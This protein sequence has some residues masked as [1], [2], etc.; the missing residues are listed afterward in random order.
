MNVIV[1]KSG[2]WGPITMRCDQAPFSDVRVRQALR[3][4]I[5]RP[6]MLAAVFGG[7]G[8]I[9]N[10][11]A[12]I[13][14]PEFVEPGPQRRQDIPQAQSLLKAAGYENLNV[15]LMTS[16]FAPGQVSTAS[17][18][19]TQAKA[20]GVN[21]KVTQQ[22]PTDYFTKSYLKAPLAV[23]YWPGWG[24]LLQA[25]LAT[26]GDA[27]FNGAHFNDP[28]YNALYARA[29]A[30]ADKTVHRDV[31]HAMSK[32]DYDRGGNIIPYFFPVI[33]AAAPHVKGI[34]PSVSGFALSFFD[35]KHFWLDQ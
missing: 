18:F 30:S 21:V 29:M 32:I 12:G 13:Y 15:E 7:Q 14:D 16:S 23:D 25:S 34:T 3:L 8:Q 4:V 1:S 6:Q 11:V 9:G 35:F 22:T 10:D 33:D 28:E 24:A 31:I 26:V 17:V 2:G 5:D 19:A 27:P 20:A